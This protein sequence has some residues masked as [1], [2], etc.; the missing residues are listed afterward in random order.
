MRL[1]RTYNNLVDYYQDRV[2][3]PL[4][5]FDTIQS[6][7]AFI[8]TYESVTSATRS[9]GTRDKRPRKDDGADQEGRENGPAGN[10]WSQKVAKN[11]NGDDTEVKRELE[12]TNCRVLQRVGVIWCDIETTF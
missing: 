11:L 3:M 10:Q 5:L 1:A 6:I 2:L 7:K 9:K 4:T 12:A 8:E